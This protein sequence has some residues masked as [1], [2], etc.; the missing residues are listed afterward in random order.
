M[1][2]FSQSNI[3]KAIELLTRPLTKEYQ[4]SHAKYCYMLYYNA[5]MKWPAY[6][7]EN[8]KR[9]RWCMTL[10]QVCLLLF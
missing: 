8:R 5:N 4:N 9:F 7:E 3:Y 1:K 6:T 10:L 2:E